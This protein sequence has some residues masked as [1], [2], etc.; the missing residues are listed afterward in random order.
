MKIS[1]M[2]ALQLPAQCEMQAHRLA[3]MSE[4]TSGGGPVQ[5]GSPC[6][7]AGHALRTG[8]PLH[9]VPLLCICQSFKI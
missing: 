1:A 7:R 3:S 4:A 9:P 2:A 5:G 6:V 8:T